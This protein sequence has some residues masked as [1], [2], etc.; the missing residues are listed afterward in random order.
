MRSSTED[1]EDVGAEDETLNAEDETLNAKDET[2]N[3]KDWWE[4]ASPAIESAFDKVRSAVSDAS[5]IIAAKVKSF[6]GD[7]FGIDAEE[8]AASAVDKAVT[9]T[10]PHI[11]PTLPGQWQSASTRTKTTSTQICTSQRRRNHVVYCQSTEARIHE[12]KRQ[13]HETV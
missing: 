10:P 5:P 9:K 4:K 6:L 1:Y 13:S 3:A 7:H 2:L 8:A 11:A 12:A